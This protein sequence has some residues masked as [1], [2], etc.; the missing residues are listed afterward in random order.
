MIHHSQVP[1]SQR[2]VYFSWSEADEREHRIQNKAITRLR[3]LPSYNSALNDRFVK[4]NINFSK[5]WS[6]ELESRS[7]CT[8][9]RKQVIYCSCYLVSI[10]S[11]FLLSGQD[12]AA[13]GFEVSDE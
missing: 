13:Y 9:C 12:L 5:I 7:R 6:S 2:H 3:E 10:F 8:L 11:T 1:S 4:H